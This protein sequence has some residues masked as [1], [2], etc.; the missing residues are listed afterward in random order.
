MKPR[1]IGIGE[2]LQNGDVEASNGALKRR[3]EQHLL[4]R[5]SREFDSVTVYQEWLDEILVQANA[6][7]RLRLPRRLR[8]CVRYRVPDCCATA[9]CGLG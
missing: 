2:S 4:L 8:R 3:L 5:G 1:T 7:R 6:L 9:R